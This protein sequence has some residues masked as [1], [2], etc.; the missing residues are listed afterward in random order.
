MGDL[1]GLEKVELG[2]DCVYSEKYFEEKEIG[3]GMF[4]V[5]SRVKR[6]KDGKVFAAKKI[7]IG[8]MD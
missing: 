5:V 3:K 1:N 7:K 2:N 8:E 4:G 6:K